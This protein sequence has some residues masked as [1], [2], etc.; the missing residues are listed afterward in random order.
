[1]TAPNDL[2]MT[3]EE[4]LVPEHTAV[5]VI[6]MQKDFTLP[7]FFSDKVG[8]VIA[9][10]P[11]VAARL[12][13]LLKAARQAGVTIIHVRADY[14]PDHMSAPMW[15]RL[16]RH[17]RDP[18]CQ[19][20]EEGIE[21]Y[22]GFEGEPGE[23]VVIKHRYDAF[24]GTELDALLRARGIRTVVITGV[25]THGCVDSTAR[26]A[27]FLDYYVVFGSDLSAGADAMMT[28]STLRTMEQCFGV[29]TSGAEIEEAWAKATKIKS[30]P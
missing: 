4:K 2:L 7:G 9:D 6:D 21:P 30:T 28:E 5:I 25:A 10:A 12:T 15:E 20:G 23:P 1:M 17:G 24:F 18:Y 13:S 8:Q 16:V 3:L 27:Y 19:P 26:H 22:P 11:A 29:C 14:R